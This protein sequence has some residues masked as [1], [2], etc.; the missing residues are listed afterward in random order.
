MTLKYQRHIPIAALLTPAESQSIA[1]FVFATDTGGGAQ[2]DPVLERYQTVFATTRA[3]YS[4]ES[5]KCLILRTVSEFAET[6]RNDTYV[7]VL[8]RNATT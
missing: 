3:G 5:H 2:T 7:Y 8:K 6:E 1:G 4:T